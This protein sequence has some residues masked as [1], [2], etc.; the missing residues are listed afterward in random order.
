M[1][2]LRDKFRNLSNA[3]KNSQS[4]KNRQKVSRTQSR[5][6]CVFQLVIL[7]L[8]NNI[9]MSKVITHPLSPVPPALETVDG[10]L[11]KTDKSNL[12]HSLVTD[13]S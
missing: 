3:S 7:A 4:K 8:Q 1:H 13:E 6:E 5:E 11:T 12:I 2:L 9:K 10:C